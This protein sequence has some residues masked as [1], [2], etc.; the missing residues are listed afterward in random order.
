MTEDRGQRTEY[1]F[2]MTEGR[3]FQFW[4]LDFG[5]R[6]GGAKGRGQKTEDRGQ[7]TEDRKQRTEDRGQR[8]DDGGQKNA[9]VIRYWL[10][11]LADRAKGQVQRAM[12]KAHGA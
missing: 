12:S 11:V 7:K 9:F 4:I 10:F 6:I 1:R 5:L 3:G 8:A 2:Q